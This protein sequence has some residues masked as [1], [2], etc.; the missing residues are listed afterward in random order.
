MG[1]KERTARRVPSWPPRTVVG[2]TAQVWGKLAVAFA[3]AA[4]AVV[5][6]PQ[7][8]TGEEQPGIGTLLATGTVVALLTTGALYV[9]L[10]SDLG[11]PASVAVF[12]VGYNALVVLVK[13]VL[14]PRGLYETSEAGRL[15]TLFD[16]SDSVGAIMISGS[17]FLAYAAVLTVIY[18][19]SRRRLGTAKRFGWARAVVVA[20]VVGAILVASGWLPLL[21]LWGGLDYTGFVLSSGVS[22]LVGL[23]LAGAVS[24]AAMTLRSSAEHARLAGD[25]ALLVTVFWLGLAFLALYHVLWVVYV[26]VLTSIWPLKVITP[27]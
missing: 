4:L 15:E 21:L 9:V 7:L 18:R 8:G 1:G 16:P 5:V 12:A 10:R 25:A 22:A 17:V 24:L 23:A 27:K 26:L 2:M 13:L 3:L 14:G 20:L 19:V 6:V 11:L